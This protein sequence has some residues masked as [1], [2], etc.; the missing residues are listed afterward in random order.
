MKVILESH[1]SHWRLSW[2][3]LVVSHQRPNIKQALIDMMLWSGVPV[4]MAMIAI[5]IDQARSHTPATYQRK[6]FIFHINANLTF[7]SILTKPYSL[8]FVFFLCLGSTSAHRLCK[9]VVSLGSYLQ[10]PLQILLDLHEQNILCVNHI[11]CSRCRSS[12]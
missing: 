2:N 8:P 6:G 1:I 10:A 7:C 11:R 4:K 9:H 5:I 3:L 12:H